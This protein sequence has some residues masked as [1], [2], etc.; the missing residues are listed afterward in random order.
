MEKFETKR[1]GDPRGTFVLLT[2]LE[3]KFTTN[4]TTNSRRKNVLNSLFLF[5]NNTLI[6]SCIIIL[7]VLATDLKAITNL[8]YFLCALLVHAHVLYICR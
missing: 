3:F 5:A 1:R 4:S 8:Y 7:C 6:E 2:R